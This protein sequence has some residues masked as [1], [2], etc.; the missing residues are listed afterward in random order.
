MNI[1]DYDKKIV[2]AFGCGEGGLYVK[3]NYDDAVRGTDTLGDIVKQLVEE[4]KFDLAQEKTKG[5]YSDY[6]D[7]IETKHELYKT[8]VERNVDS[9]ISEQLKFVEDFLENRKESHPELCGSVAGI[10]FREGKLQEALD[11]LEV[12]D[13]EE[14]RYWD[15]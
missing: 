7:Y 12:S 15:S 3:E 11:F 14:N 8:L 10:L 6:S 13:M 2:F 9:N 5:K 1:E 4:M